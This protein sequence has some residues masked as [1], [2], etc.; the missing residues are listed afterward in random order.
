MWSDGMAEDT[1]E[2]ALLL[3][4]DLQFVLG[5]EAGT[6]WEQLKAGPD[7]LE[8]QIHTANLDVIRDMAH[9][10]GYQLEVQFLGDG[11]EAVTFRRME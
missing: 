5:F 8:T 4:D 2:L 7:V 10:L 9:R 11:W 1:Y 6:H 3:P